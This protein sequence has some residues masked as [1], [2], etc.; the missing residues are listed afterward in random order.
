MTDFHCIVYYKDG[1]SYK[2]VLNE[3]HIYHLEQIASVKKIK[4]GKEVK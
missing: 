4:V 2:T 3:W 1:S